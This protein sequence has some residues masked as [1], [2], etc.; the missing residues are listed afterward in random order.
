MTALATPPTPARRAV[1]TLGQPLVVL[2][3]RLVH[4]APVRPC[5][6]PM[7]PAPASRPRRLL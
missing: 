6:S 2:D 7:P 5:L 3:G 1:C 4:L